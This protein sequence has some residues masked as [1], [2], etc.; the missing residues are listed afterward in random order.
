MVAML[1]AAGALF[2]LSGIILRLATDAGGLLG[3]VLCLRSL[4]GVTVLALVMRRVPTTLRR[5]TARNGATLASQFILFA[6]SIQFLNPGTAAILSYTSL[7]WVPLLALFW[8]KQKVSLIDAC[9][10]FALIGA[11]TLYFVDDLSFDEKFGVALALATGFVWSLG[12]VGSSKSSGESEHGG[13][14]SFFIGGSML[15]CA[16]A[17]IWIFNRSPL[18]STESIGWATGGGVAAGFAICFLIKPLRALNST[19]VNI[20]LLVDPILASVWSWLVFGKQPT[21]WAFIGGATIL[22]ILF[23]SGLLQM[24][25]K[26]HPPLEIPPG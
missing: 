16:G 14:D 12:I 18:P 24:K 2:S 13:L 25:F 10:S 26:R 17:A 20:G 1:V 7:F 5:S 8:A 22:G 11:V 6:C 19:S 9:T 15:A 21:L 4:V 3:P 23:V